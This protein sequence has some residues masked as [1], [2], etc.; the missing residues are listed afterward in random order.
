MD[1]T[2]RGNTT[3]SQSESRGNNNE[4]VFH[5]SEFPGLEPHH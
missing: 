5:T 3:P 1:G 2:L 4:A